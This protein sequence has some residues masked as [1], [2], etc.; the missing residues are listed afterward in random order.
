M[1]WVPGEYQS[2]S[3]ESSLLLII[4]DTS[5]RGNSGVDSSSPADSD[6][7]RGN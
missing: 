5:L 7:S 4:V 1:R 6:G 3:I 2:S